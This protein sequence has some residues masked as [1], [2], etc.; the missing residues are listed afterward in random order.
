LFRL[1]ERLGIPILPGSDPLPLPGEAARVGSYGFSVEVESQPDNIARQLCDLLREGR[2]A[3][4]PYGRLI[5]P[6]RFI[7]NQLALRLRKGGDSGERA[8]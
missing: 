8:R 6:V 7:R 3:V 4:H 5:G 2:A 1:A